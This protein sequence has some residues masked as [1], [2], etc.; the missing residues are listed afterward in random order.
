MKIAIDELVTKSENIVNGKI[1]YVVINFHLQMLSIIGIDFSRLPS[2][3]GLMKKFN[4]AAVLTD[5][6]W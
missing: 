2:M 1:L 4:R 6:K 5:K 3:L